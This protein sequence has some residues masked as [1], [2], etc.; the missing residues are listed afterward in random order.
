MARDGRG[1]ASGAPGTSKVT[2]LSLPRRDAGAWR[3]GAMTPAAESWR[4]MKHR[5][6][7]DVKNGSLPAMAGNPL[8]AC[9]QRFSAI[10]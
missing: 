4:L 7:N 1:A 10:Y 2:A 5:C 9:S 6:A 8:A 3:R